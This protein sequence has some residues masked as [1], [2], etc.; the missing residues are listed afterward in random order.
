MNKKSVDSFI[1]R[2]SE[3]VAIIGILPSTMGVTTELLL[4]IIKSRNQ[5]VYSKDIIN[6]FSNVQKQLIDTKNDI[7]TLLSEVE[8]QKE[9]FIELKEKADLNMQTIQFTDDEVNAIE[10]VLSK[11]VVREGKKNTKLTIILG[12]IFAILGAIIGFFLG[13]YF[14]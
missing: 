14:G 12:L 10:K 13:K 7:S 2:L 5:K 6:S 8:K 3:M 4:K 11:S 1:N 9:N